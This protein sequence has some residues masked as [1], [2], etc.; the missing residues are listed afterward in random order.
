VITATGLSSFEGIEEP[1]VTYHPQT[2]SFTSGDTHANITDVGG[3]TIRFALRYSPEWWDGDRAT[4]NRDR[5]RAEV[6]GLGPHQK[7]GE[8]FTYAME[9]RTNREFVG[10]ERFCHIFQ[11]KA[12]DGDNGAPLVTLSLKEGTDL[13]QLQLWSGG[14]DER[15]ARK[16]QWR[17]GE[18]H[19]TQIVIT[20][21]IQKA[22]KVLASINGDALDGL[23]DVAVY[24]PQATD[25][26]PKWGLYR[27]T[28]ASLHAGEDWIEHRK[29]SA[30]KKG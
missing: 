6:K 28:A 15:V 9:W 27:G 13:G 7:T 4:G 29:I 8:T 25:Y 17:P 26:R 2:K 18:W 3:G 5:Q 30:T 1:T 23:S 10:S 22:G 12:T 21:S 14:D 20:T 16:F 19:R 11:L 24:R